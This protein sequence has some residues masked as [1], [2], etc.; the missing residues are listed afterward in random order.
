MSYKK[1]FIYIETYIRNALSI[2]VIN[3]NQYLTQNWK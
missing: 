2:Q 3:L 1:G